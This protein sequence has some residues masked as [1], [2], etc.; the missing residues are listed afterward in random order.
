VQA[1]AAHGSDPALADESRTGC[2]RASGPDPK[3]L[4][5]NADRLY[6]QFR[7]KEA[8]GELHKVLQSDPHN[9]EATV[10]LCRAH[11]DIGDM[12][13]ESAQDWKER[14][15]KE[16]RTAEDYARKAVTINPN[17]AWGHFYIA[18][19]LGNMAVLSPVAKQIDLAA[20]IRSAVEK[21]I[22]LDP[23]NGFAYHIYGVWHR[24]MAEIGKTRRMF[25]SFVYGRSVPTG[26]LEKSVEYLKKAVAL[27][28]TVWS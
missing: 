7:T 1:G 2:C 26:S 16:Y 10:K 11:I 14:R 17:S 15:M 27:N 5:K 12:I 19:S 22:A 4:L 6:A 8:A 18:A 24:K 9:L 13:P 20:E 25:A 21:A 3:Q 23:Q 28:P